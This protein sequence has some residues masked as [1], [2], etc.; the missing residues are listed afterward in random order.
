MLGLFRL[1][2]SRN[3]CGITLRALSDHVSQENLVA[4][5]LSD[6]SVTWEP[7]LMRL[8]SAPSRA[9]DA[10]WDYCARSFS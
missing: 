1:C 7:T 2:A 4:I 10:F 8:T 5:P 3:M 9:Q 6:D